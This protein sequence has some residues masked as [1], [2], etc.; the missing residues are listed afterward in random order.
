MKD[1]SLRHSLLFWIMIS[2]ITLICL[3]LSIGIYQDWAST[4]ERGCTKYDS[5]PLYWQYTC[6]N[7]VFYEQ[8]G[9]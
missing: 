8:K 3:I 7:K 6:G 2:A 9:V 1:D 4:P 5:A